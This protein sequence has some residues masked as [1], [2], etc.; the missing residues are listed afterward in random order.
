VTVGM[1]YLMTDLIAGFA[2]FAGVFLGKLW[3]E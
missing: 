1:Q 3:P 2:G